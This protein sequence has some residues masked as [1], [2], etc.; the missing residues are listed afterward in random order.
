MISFDLSWFILSKFQE[1]NAD[2][3]TLRVFFNT[4]C[5]CI[6]YREMI[7]NELRKGVKKPH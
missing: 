4:L 2:L 7:Y 5:I 1:K 6:L 3:G